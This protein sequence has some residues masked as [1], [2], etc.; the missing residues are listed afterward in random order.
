[1]KGEG[2]NVNDAERLGIPPPLDL[3]IVKMHEFDLV[4]PLLRTYE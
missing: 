1:M 3:F 2:R 4:P